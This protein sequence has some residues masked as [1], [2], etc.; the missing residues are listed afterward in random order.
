VK[1]EIHE[2]LFFPHQLSTNPGEGHQR[3][4][5]LFVLISLKVIVLQLLLLGVNFA[6]FFDCFF[7]FA[8]RFDCYEGCIVCVT[9]AYASLVFIHTKKIISKDKHCVVLIII[10]TQTIKDIFMID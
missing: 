7:P 4:T 10:R 6:S 3:P 2:L 8:F 9:F 5:Y 1:F